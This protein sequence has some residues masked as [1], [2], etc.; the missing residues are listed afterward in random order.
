MKALR[1][2]IAL[3]LA[4]SVGAQQ[5]AG[6][7]DA[8]SGRLE[9]TTTSDVAK[10]EYRA[11]WADLLNLRP[12]IAREH[13]LKAVAAD[14]GFGLAQMFLAGPLSPQLSADERASGVAKAFATAST[15]S[16][17]E[18]M[19]A[20]YA[21]EAFSGRNQSALAII[22]AL[23]P[24][25]PNDPDVAYQLWQSEAAGRN[26]AENLRT[27][28]EFIDRFPDY[29]YAYNTYAYSLHTLGD[30]TGDIAAVQQYVRL[31]PT[32]P[33]AHDTWADL[34]L[35]HGHADAAAAHVEA[36]LKI[37]S[38]WRGRAK[39]G[40][41]RLAT[42]K[43]DEARDIFTREMAA[44]TTA[45]ERV[46]AHHWIAAIYIYN[47]DGKSALRELGAISGEATA[48]KLPANAL[49]LPHLRMALVEATLGN[50]QNVAGHLAAAAQIQGASAAQQAVYATYAY[51][52]AGDAKAAQESADAFAKTPNANPQVTHLLNAYAALAGKNYTAAETELGQANQ[53]NLLVKALRAE[54]LKQQGKTAE[55]RAL[56]E[57]VLRIGVKN[58]GNNAVDVTKLVA[59][60][61][62][63]KL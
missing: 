4:S 19:F 27:L 42:G 61:R 39:L 6:G 51:G 13:G 7:S 3:A 50:K 44:G 46:D 37:D 1:V 49:A 10:S 32:Q 36:S 25:V 40:A 30:H 55:A 57:E 29:A 56:K 15:G 33:N 38:T 12:N 17:T 18:V 60:L 43:A 8:A 14:P 52:A 16:A 20:L 28:K 31:A 53:T 54:V 45:Q 26:A 23:A 59:K 41:I 11:M 48:G 35:L 58:D 24:M 34:E 21:R 9:L 62:V 63:D 5:Q 22:R 2:A 47:R